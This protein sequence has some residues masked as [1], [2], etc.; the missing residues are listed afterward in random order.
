M[1]VDLNDEQAMTHT[2]IKCTHCMLEIVGARYHCAICESVDICSN[3]D[4]AGLPGN[5]DSSDDHAHNSSHIMIK[6]PYPLAPT[7]VQTAS[8]RAVRLWT[9]RDAANVNHSTSSPGS[10]SLTSSSSNS[11]SGNG[12]GS[13]S[14]G[15][16]HALNYGLA[17]GGSGLGRQR[18]GSD[19]SSYAGTVIAASSRSRSGLG[20]GGVG[21]RGKSWKCGGCNELIVGV[22]YQCAN[23]PSLPN[24]FN[25]CAVCEIRSHQLHDPMHAFFKIPRPLDKEIE[26]SFPIVPIL[27]KAPVGSGSYSPDY[28]KSVFHSS[29]V[30]D[31][32]MTRIQGA[33]FRCAY[34]A[35]DL[36]D[37]CEE[38]DTHDDKHIFIVFKS[39]VDMLVFRRFTDLENPT[40]GPPL[41][42]HPVFN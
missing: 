35:K 14:N 18:R 26:S 15:T 4:A 33:W 2:G 9:G 6:I 20:V 21:G 1:G 11:N 36:C 22:R 24:A 30:C 28:L 13:S 39:P 31:R 7:E 10:G 42:S 34:C 3:C 29:A 12:I 5:L 40:G 37:A 16:I 8:R 32:C 41:I 19:A 27:Y 23:C 25:L 38:L 17:Y